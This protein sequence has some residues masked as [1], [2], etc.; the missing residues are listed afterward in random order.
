MLRNS[1]FVL[2]ASKNQFLAEKALAI[3][4]CVVN[5]F[6]AMRNKVVSGFTF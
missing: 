5:V 2:A 6:E 4:S 3:V 1:F